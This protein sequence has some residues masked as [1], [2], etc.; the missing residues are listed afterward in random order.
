VIYRNL[1]LEVEEVET[2]STTANLAPVSVA[3]HVTALG[4]R[5]GTIFN[6]VTTEAFSRILN[7]SKG[8]ASVL[9]PLRTFGSSHLS[10]GDLSDDWER[11]ASCTFAIATDVRPILDTSIRLRAVVVLVTVQ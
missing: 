8:E 2:A 9:T 3:G 10:A 4:G 5:E 7:T 1:H 11:T 6:L